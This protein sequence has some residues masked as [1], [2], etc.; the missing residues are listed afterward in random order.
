[1]RAKY[2]YSCRGAGGRLSWRQVRR[3]WDRHGKLSAAAEPV[4]P[5]DEPV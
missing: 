4:A 5:S 3:L 1:M 2:W